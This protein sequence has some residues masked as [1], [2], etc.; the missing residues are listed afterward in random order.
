MKRTVSLPT[1]A[2][3]AAWGIA[4]SLLVSQPAQAGADPV[5][6]AVNL[7]LANDTSDQTILANKLQEKGWRKVETAA[8][9]SSLSYLAAVE[10]LMVYE[11][12][13]EMDK[14]P[15]G[16]ARIKTQLTDTPEQMFAAYENVGIFTH[17][18]LGATVLRSNGSRGR[19]FCR[20]ALSP[21]GLDSAYLWQLRVAIELKSDEKSYDMEMATHIDGPDTRTFTL[22][23]S[24]N[25]TVKDGN[26]S[27][28]GPV[29]GK[30]RIRQITP[31]KDSRAAFKDLFDAAGYV[32]TRLIAKK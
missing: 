27:R 29:L 12:T 30:G 22:K 1:S 15:Q 23:A 18:G 31:T 9:L 19:Q 25:T 17:P 8:A 13:G 7:C 10:A 4:L 6:D 14:I 11:R 21:R 16:K 2:P 32:S 28:P 5:A 3:L 24:I 26:T 20:M